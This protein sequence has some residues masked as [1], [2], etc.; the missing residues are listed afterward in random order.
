MKFDGFIYFLELS[1]EVQM[2]I[3]RET[4]KNAVGSYW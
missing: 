1:K 4:C 2:C 3:E